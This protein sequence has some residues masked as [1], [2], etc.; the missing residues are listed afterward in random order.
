MSSSLVMMGEPVSAFDH[1]LPSL[2]FDS[3][4]L[5][6]VASN[7][8]ACRLFGDD[9]AATTAAALFRENEQQDAQGLKQQLE[10]LVDQT[11]ASREQPFES[12]LPVTLHYWTGPPEARGAHLAEVL[13]LRCPAIN[14]SAS[15]NSSTYDILFLRLIPQHSASEPSGVAQPTSAG[16]SLRS[17]SPRPATDRSFP[18]EPDVLDK[19]HNTVFKGVKDKTD[20]TLRAGGGLDLKEHDLVKVSEGYCSVR[21]AYS[22]GHL[23]RPCMR[24]AGV[25]RRSRAVSRP[26]SAQSLTTSFVPLRLSVAPQVLD[27]FPTIAFVADAVSVA[28]E[29]CRE[30]SGYAPSRSASIRRTFELP[31][32]PHRSK[33]GRKYGNVDESM[34]FVHWY[35]L[36]HFFRDLTAADGARSPFFSRFVSPLPQ[37]SP[38]ISGVDKDPS[39]WVSAFHPDELGGVLVVMQLQILGRTEPGPPQVLS[40]I[41][42][43]RSPRGPRGLFI[44]S[45]GFDRKKGNGGGESVAEVVALR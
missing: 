35:R 41:G 11:E 5:Q 9:L 6:L 40:L 8:A 22:T 28:F 24:V 21:N 12:S 25:R 13:C 45:I 17:A 27:T 1:F 19:F 31:A 18:V 4:T 37:L 26:T 32:D 7:S 39:T 34:V 20:A 30:L 15:S 10:D 43:G 36:S 33:I 42:W 23:Y 2:S 44:G 16:S 38:H 3:S 29:N 14:E